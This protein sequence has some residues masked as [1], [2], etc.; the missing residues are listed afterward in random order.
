MCD[1]LSEY[2]TMYASAAGD[3]PSNV[4][5]R[6]DTK[7]LPSTSHH[8]P[9][10]ALSRKPVVYLPISWMDGAQ[11]GSTVCG[12]QL[13][14]LHLQRCAHRRLGADAGLFSDTYLWSTVY[15]WIGRECRLPDPGM[16]AVVGK[17]PASSPHKWSPTGPT[18][19][20][21]SDARSARNV[22]PRTAVQSNYC[23]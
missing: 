10:E 21:S 12:A 18:L 22:Q 19:P 13:K 17:P 15:R 1:N 4:T 2:E 5:H 9:P 7:Q 23:H 14:H 16:Y 20:L 3:Y 11:V 6:Y 8:S